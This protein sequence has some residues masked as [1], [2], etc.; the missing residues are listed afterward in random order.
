MGAYGAQPTVT[1]TGWSWYFV[2]GVF[3]FSNLIIVLLRIVGIYHGY[4]SVVDSQLA[5]PTLV[6]RTS[7]VASV[8]LNV[9]P[10]VSIGAPASGSEAGASTL[11]D[12]VV[13]N[14]VFCPT[15]VLNGY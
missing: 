2:L 8:V 12:L 1:A 3:L 4:S 14:V 5:T 13:C 9:E 6:P 7:V 15:V 11:S 10:A